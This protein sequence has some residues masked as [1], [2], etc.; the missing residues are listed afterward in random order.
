MVQMIE[1]YRKLSLRLD[2][3]AVIG[4]SEKLLGDPNGGPVLLPVDKAFS[5]GLVTER[6][7]KRLEA[8]LIQMHSRAPN[9]AP[10]RSLSELNRKRKEPDSA[11][12][13]AGHPKAAHLNNGRRGGKGERHSMGG[14]L[15]NSSW[16]GGD[17]YAKCTEI[18]TEVEKNLGLNLYIF[19][20]PVKAADYPEYHKVV[21]VPMDLGTMRGRLEGRQYNNPQEFCDDMRQVWINC[22]LYNHKDTVVGKAGSRADAK[23]E[24]LWAASGYDQGGRRRRVTGGIAAHKYEPSLDPEPKPPARKTSS[25]GQR[26][27]RREGLQ[28]MKSV[29]NKPMPMEMMQ[30]LASR[31]GQFA[32]DD[33]M[34]QIL[35]II[36]EGQTVELQSNGEVELDFDTLENATLWRLWDFTENMNLPTTISPADSEPSDSDDSGD[37]PG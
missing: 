1:K 35:S 3:G 7:V 11:Q 29:N 16:G 13:L 2:N 37:E 32:E 6:Q 26:N 9:A 10:L 28:R 12:E 27:G 18:L 30:E 31:L 20:A 5:R 36:R 25:S 22:A 4:H 15:G 21:K 23:F 34:E 33:N 19:A 8:L 14:S 17:F 24:Q